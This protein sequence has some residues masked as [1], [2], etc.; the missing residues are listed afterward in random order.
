MI[1]VTLGTQNNDFTRCLKE[2]EKLV[3]EGVINEEVV[4]QVGYTQYRPEGI[5][6][7]DFVSE[8]DYQRYVAEARV[9][10]SHAGSGALFSAVKRGTKTIAMA[11]LA[12]YGEMPNDH[13]LE[14][15][16]KL[17]QGGYILDGTYD[18]KSAWDK[19]DSFTP[20]ENDI[21]CGIPERIE[22][23]LIGWG[24]NKNGDNI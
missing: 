22:Q 19:V 13:Q 12:K 21:K 5:K 9:V 10:I 15:V 20:R 8:N 17:T 4:A 2:V 6:C 3:N 16:E 23:L 24:V 14:L 1:Y 18:L 7:I 11:R